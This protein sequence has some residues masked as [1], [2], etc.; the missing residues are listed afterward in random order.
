VK[1]FRTSLL[2]VCTLTVLSTSCVKLNVD[3]PLVGK[4]EKSSSKKRSNLVSN[5][6][7]SVNKLIGDDLI[8]LQVISEKEFELQKLSGK[9]LKVSSD[10]GMKVLGAIPLTQNR[11]KS[12]VRKGM[13]AGQVNEESLLLGFP[14]GLIGEQNIFGGVITKVTDKTSEPLGGLKLTDLSPLNV[15][16]AVAMDGEDAVLTL[17][18]CFKDCGEDSAQTGLINFPI[19]GIDKEN[20]KVM[21]DLSA[22][23]K[24]L[25]LMKM[26]DPKGEYTK[27]KSVSSTTTTFDYSFS[28]LVFDVKSKMVPLDADPADP[29]TPVT[30]FTVRWYLKLGSAFN[31]AFTPR[32]PTEGVGFFKTERSKT[33]MIT[34]FS[35]TD[36]GQPVK[37]YIKFVPE[38]YKSYFS[39]ALDNWNKEF[40]KIIGRD[41]IS[42]EFIDAADPRA[43]ELV[44]GDIRYNIIEWDLNNLAAYGGLGP[45]IANQ[46]TGET[47]SANVLVQG[48]TIIATYTKWFELSKTIRRLTAEGRTSEADILVTNFHRASD[49]ELAQRKKVKFSLSLGEAL[50]MNIHSQRKELEDPMIKN[51]FD[52]VPPGVTFEKYMAGYFTEMIEHEVGHNLGL[53][54]NFKGNLGAYET[55]EPGSVSRSIMEYLGRPYRHLSAIGLYDKM[56]LAYGYKGVMPKHLNWFCSDEDQGTDKVTLPVKSPECNKTDATSDPF[57]YLESRLARAIDLL[58]DVNSTSAPVWTAKDLTAQMDEILTGLIAYAASAEKTMSTWTNFLGKGDRPEDVAGVKAYVLQA[59]KKKICAPE[60]T[61][62]IAAK[63]TPEAVKLAGENLDTLRKAFEKKSVDIAVFTAEE[64]KCE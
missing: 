53:R 5:K 58:V 8:Q 37:Y 61:A 15:K 34:R 56:A 55:G 24:V 38:Q 63:E 33:P 22:V 13:K 32:A 47:L 3:I 40:T 41:L 43:E 57:S 4:Q 17:I 18:G 21:L 11:A 27:L 59:L 14:I 19:L 7:P 64:V 39:G 52:V 10:E 51:H 6:N 20:D 35:T 9:I 28:T 25:D 29:K 23:G 48:P 49:Q 12:S 44:T 45:S 46:F 16:T 50:T 26:L 54:H 1:I 36:F 2:S 60:L 62:V 31:P 42:Y 30:E